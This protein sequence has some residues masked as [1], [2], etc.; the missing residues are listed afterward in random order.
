ME[1]SYAT[2]SGPASLT[3]RRAL[4]DVQADAPK[5]LRGLG[6]PA[7]ALGD[8]VLWGSLL[9]E[10]TLTADELGTLAQLSTLRHVGAGQNVLCRSTGA[11]NLALPPAIISTPPLADPPAPLAEPGPIEQPRMGLAV[12]SPEPVEAFVPCDPKPALAPPPPPSFAPPPPPAHE[13]MGD[14]AAPPPEPEPSIMGGLSVREPPPA[15]PQPGFAPPPP[16]RFA[17]PPSD[18]GFAPPPQTR[19][20]PPPPGFAPPP[21]EPHDTPLMGSVSPAVEVPERMGRIAPAPR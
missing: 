5:P 1:H 6:L 20:A 15:P 11:D 2:P 4:P 17:P 16:T 9:G 18:P 10:P 7:G 3:G 13:R 12:A 14:I 21:P 8:A 19:F